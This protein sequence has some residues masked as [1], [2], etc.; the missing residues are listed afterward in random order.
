ME[1]VPCHNMEFD[2]LHGY[3]LHQLLSLHML[4]YYCIVIL[5]YVMQS[6][7]I[8][9]KMDFV[10]IELHSISN[11]IRQIMKTLNLIKESKFQ[12]YTPRKLLKV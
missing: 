10:D 9:H 7:S 6:C 1:V 3:F 2:L 12:V 11:M 8:L 4:D 5:L